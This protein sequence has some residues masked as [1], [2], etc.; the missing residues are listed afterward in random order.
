[1]LVC[2]WLSFSPECDSPCA[3]SVGLL[4]FPAGLKGSATCLLADS[5]NKMSLRFQGDALEGSSACFIVLITVYELFKVKM[6]L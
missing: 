2:K 5:G 3:C 6:C 4:F 1:M